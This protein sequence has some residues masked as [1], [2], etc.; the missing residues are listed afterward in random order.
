MVYSV[1]SATTVPSAVEQPAAVDGDPVAL[2]HRGEDL[3]TDVVD[4]R[5]AGLQQDARAEIRDSGRTP[6]APR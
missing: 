2:V 5:D 3:L 6:T 4:Q 1:P